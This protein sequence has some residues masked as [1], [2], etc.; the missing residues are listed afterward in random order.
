MLRQGRL[1]GTGRS[2]LALI[3]LGAGGCLS[4]TPPVDVRPGTAPRC[5]GDVC[6]EIVSAR[7]NRQTIGIW[8]DAPSGTKLVNAGVSRAAAAPCRAGH[9]VE[10]VAVGRQV[11]TAG[12]ADVGGAHGLVLSFPLAIW[13]VDAGD[14]FVELELDIAGSRRCVRSRLMDARNNLAVGS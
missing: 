6:V 7:L 9:K 4:F 5:H 10:W 13:H 8:I 11:L 12:P 1:S 3:L 14:N 2:L